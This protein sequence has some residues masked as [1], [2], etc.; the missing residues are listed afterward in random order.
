MVPAAA[1]VLLNIVMISAIWLWRDVWVLPY[2][3]LLTGLL[4]F[5]LHCWDLWRCGA[6][7]VVQWR[8]SPELKELRRALIPVLVREWGVSDQCPA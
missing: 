1:P 8:Q 5:A 4:Q 3:V 2:A 7:P 6:I